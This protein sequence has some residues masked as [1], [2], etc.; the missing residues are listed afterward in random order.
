MGSNFTLCCPLCSL[1]EIAAS[2]ISTTC[3]FAFSITVSPYIYQPSA[4]FLMV[5]VLNVELCFDRL[6]M[7]LLWACSTIGIEI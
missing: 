4:A 2:S 7:I 5:R 1:Q 3:Y 6:F